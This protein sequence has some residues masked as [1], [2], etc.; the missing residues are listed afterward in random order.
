MKRRGFTLIELLVVIAIIAILIGLL[1]PAVQKVREAA[2]RTDTNNNLRQIG[3]ACHNC[4]DSFKK[5]PPAWAPFGSTTPFFANVHLH[6]M[7]F[8]EQQPLYNQ[9][10][11]SGPP[12]APPNTAATVDQAVIKPYLSPSD[13]TTTGTGAGQTNFCANIRVFA[14]GGRQ[15]LYNASMDFTKSPS[16]ACSVGIANGFP[17]GTTNTILFATRYS[18]DASGIKTRI[19]RDPT[20]AQGPYF[21]AYFATT[22]AGNQKLFTPAASSPPPAGSVVYTFQNAPSVA[23]V[24]LNGSTYAQSYGA[25]GLSVVLGDASVRQINVGM[26]AET[27]NRGVHP[28]DGLPNGSDWDS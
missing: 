7:P 11:G 14:D 23:N 10:L 4:N 15:T 27:W 1:V 16:F 9:W 24:L 28:N 2:A 18:L 21:G 5:L 17:D 26:S 25:S 19:L 6:L 3:L 22:G 12:P 8:I 13:P 20:D